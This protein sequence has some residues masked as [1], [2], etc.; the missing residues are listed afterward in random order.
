M[1]I[2]RKRIRAIISEIFNESEQH[3]VHGIDNQNKYLDILYNE[4]KKQYSQLQLSLSTTHYYQAVESVKSI[5]LYMMRNRISSNYFHIKFENNVLIIEGESEIGNFKNIA[6]IG[7]LITHLEAEFVVE[8]NKLIKKNKI[9]ELK[10]KAILGTINQ[11]AIEDGFEYSYTQD[12]IKL[13]LFI[14]LNA[15][16][17]LTIN[18]PF[19]KFQEALGQVRQTIKTI[20]EL[21]E[22]GITFKIKGYS[23]ISWKKGVEQ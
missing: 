4:I 8:Q 14:R 10:T 5:T 6:K 17:M 12:T 23:G 7:E 13:V 3:I 21:Q 20:R 19:G 2:S 9:K 18:I 22:A 15:R 1:A 16:D 11:M